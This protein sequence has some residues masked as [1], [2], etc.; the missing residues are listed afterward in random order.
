MKQ[1][2]AY[3]LILLVFLAGCA[4]TEDSSEVISP[5]TLDEFGNE[6]YPIDTD[7]STV[8]AIGSSSKESHQINFTEWSGALKYKDGKLNGATG[9]I[10][11]TSLTS[12][13]KALD[14]D[15][16]GASFFFTSL[17]P[18]I[19]IESNTFI[20]NEEG[21]FLE[22]TLTLRGISKTIMVPVEVTD[23]G[24]KG[25]YTL[26]ISDFQMRYLGV[27]NDVLVVYDIY[28]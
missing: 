23:Y 24:L 9:V 5:A 15:L 19:I 28:I 18:D 12:G 6:L 2:F 4:T 14:E 1:L 3:V 26:D 13:I 27:S 11:A 17:A 16:H 10:K 21:S 22:T 7:K 8:Y 20:E 25:E